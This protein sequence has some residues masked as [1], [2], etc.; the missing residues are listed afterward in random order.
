MWYPPS[1]IKAFNK[2]L[3]MKP[4]AGRKAPKLSTQDHSQR[5]PLG[6]TPKLPDKSAVMN[7]RPRQ[8]QI[9]RNAIK[10]QKTAVRQKAKKEIEQDA[11]PS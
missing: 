7:S 11:Q 10:A 9:I 3:S 1:H 2:A 5:N 8:K 4:Y 6:A